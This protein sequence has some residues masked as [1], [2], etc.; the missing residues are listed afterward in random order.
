ML[1][2]LILNLI[3]VLFV[4]AEKFKTVNF[5]FFS[6]FK[7]IFC[8]RTKLA[9]RILL[10]RKQNISFPLTSKENVKIS[11]MTNKNK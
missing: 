5:C 9:V 8:V 10:I 3:F 7:S 6:F 4:F 11:E 1:L 2:N